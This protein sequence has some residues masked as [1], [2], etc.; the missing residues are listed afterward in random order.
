MAVWIPILIIYISAAIFLPYIQN[1]FT[2][3]ATEQDIDSLTNEFKDNTATDLVSLSGIF[4]NILGL[5]FIGFAD[6][7]F[8]LDAFFTLLAVIILIL[9]YRAV[10]GIG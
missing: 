8:W 7:P 6:I 10:R 1:A 9:L 4:I 5:A 2:L 3:P